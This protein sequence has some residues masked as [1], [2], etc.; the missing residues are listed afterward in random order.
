M[1]NIQSVKEER[2]D[3]NKRQKEELALGRAA[4][5]R[6]QI[7]RYKRDMGQRLGE[8]KKIFGRKHPRIE[9]MRAFVA[10]PPFKIIDP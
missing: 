3:M 5:V 10:F 1:S 8:T 2:N 7:S 4:A 9:D 6:G